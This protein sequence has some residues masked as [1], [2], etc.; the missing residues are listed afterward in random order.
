[1]WQKLFA[2][3][4]PE[5]ELTGRRSLDSFKTYE[6]VT[7]HQNVEVSKI[8]SG[9][10]LCAST[11][12]GVARLWQGVAKATPANNTTWFLF[13]IKPRIMHRQHTI[14]IFLSSSQFNF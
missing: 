4:I 14:Y 3:G 12:S 1:M 11:S 13:Y 9:Q 6:S 2:A 8:L 10:D 5:R 7:E